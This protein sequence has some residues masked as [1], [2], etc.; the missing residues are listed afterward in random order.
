MDLSMIISNFIEWAI[1]T[2][3]SL[4]VGLIVLS[5]GWKVINRVIRMLTTVL[6]KREIDETLV[7]FLD[8]L[9]AVLLRAFLI[10]IV[11]GIVGLN[12]ASL[13]AL[14][15]SAGLAI[16]LAMQGSLSNFAG[17]VIILF[18]R[19]FKVGDYIKNDSFE[20]SV[21]AI[22][23][24]YTQLT[25]VDNKVIFIPNGSLA[26][27]TITNYSAK[28]T[29]RL[30]FTFGISY[31]TD[32][33]RAKA[34]IADVLAKHEHV[35]KDPAPFIGV[36]EHAASSVNLIVLLWCPSE[37]YWPTYYGIIEEVK[38]AFDAEQIEIPFPQLDVHMK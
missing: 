12:T 19:P 5:I 21:E 4:L 27:G 7:G 2:V 26:N 15:A 34:V 38:L 14:F 30:D 23:I 3:A 25:T 29:R 11:M 18:L 16:G 8:A 1:P 37:F 24:F 6:R 28:P 31:Q 20:G 22:K 32:V 17:G 10:L 35:L 36:S 9:V 33:K 13:A